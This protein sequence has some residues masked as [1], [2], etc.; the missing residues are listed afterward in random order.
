MFTAKLNK[1]L[2][3]LKHNCKRLPM[4]LNTIKRLLMLKLF[5]GYATTTAVRE[6][7]LKIL[8]VLIN[9]GTHNLHVKR[10]WGNKD[11][12]ESIKELSDRVFNVI[13]GTDITNFAEAIM[14]LLNKIMIYLII[15]KNN[16]FL[17]IYKK[18]K[19]KNHAINNY[20]LAKS[21]NP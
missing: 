12:I 8:E 11:H 10:T 3:M 13:I 2:Q 1:R 9:G 19:K 6:G 15:N 21:N 4:L 7:H 17:Y 5:W 16:S 20:K 14:S 18:K